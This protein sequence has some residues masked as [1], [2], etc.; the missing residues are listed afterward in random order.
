MFEH[1][2]QSNDLEI[3]MLEKV[4]GALRLR[5]CVGNASGTQHLKRVQ[6]NRPASQSG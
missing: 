4:E 6:K 5:R 2:V 3:R 1:R